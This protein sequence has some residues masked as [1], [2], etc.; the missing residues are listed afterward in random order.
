MYF[1]LKLNIYIYVKYIHICIYLIN[2][3][4]FKLK[5]TAQVLQSIH[6]HLFLIYGLLN[7]QLQNRYVYVWIP[8]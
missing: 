8:R 4:D 6:L 7:Y 1:I 5:Q 3:I 2:Y